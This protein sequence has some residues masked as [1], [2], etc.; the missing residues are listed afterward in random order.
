MQVTI[1]TTGMSGVRNMF[2]RMTGRAP[3]GAATMSNQMAVLTQNLVREYASGRPGPQVITGEYRSSIAVTQLATPGIVA[4]AI[5]GTDAPQAM[6]LEFGFVG[7]DAIGRHYSQP[8][9]PHWRP[10]L[11]EAAQHTPGLRDLFFS[12]IAG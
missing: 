6:R 9:F 7:V 4:E 11:S 8:P 1:E 5:V 3:V 2:R 12:I 10:G